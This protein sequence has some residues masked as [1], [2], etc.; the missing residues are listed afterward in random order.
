[1]DTGYANDVQLE[2]SIGLGIIGAGMI[3]DYHA[4]A[5]ADTMEAVYFRRRRRTST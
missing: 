2:P 4:G 5:I 3:A 1:M